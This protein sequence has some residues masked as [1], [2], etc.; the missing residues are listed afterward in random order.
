MTVNFEGNTLSIP[1]YYRRK[2]DLD[3]AK[4]QAIAKKRSEEA[5]ASILRTH[6]IEL[7]DKYKGIPVSLQLYNLKRDLGIFR[8][9]ELENRA[10]LQHSSKGSL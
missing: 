10:S 8:Q 5:L 9:Q 6:N 2:L 3:S 1:R 4:I 7:P